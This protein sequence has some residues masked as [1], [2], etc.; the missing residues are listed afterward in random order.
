MRRLSIFSLFAVI[1][2]T[3]IAQNVGPLSSDKMFDGSI[4]ASDNEML[5]ESFPAASVKPTRTS[6]REIASGYH[7]QKLGYTR[8]DN[9]SSDF[10][11]VIPSQ[12]YDS[13]A[14]E[15]KTFAEDLHA[16]RNCGVYVEAIGT[17]TAAQVK[18]LILSY[19]STL[20]GT[21][22]IGNVAECMFEIENDYND[23]IK[24]G[25]RIW[26][27]DLYFM[28][29][30]GIWSDTDNNGVY[31]SHTG[32][33]DPDII[34]GR[35]SAQG[36]LSMGSEV[37]LIRRQLQK[38]H[39]FWWNTSFNSGDIILNYIYR[40]W[41]YHFPPQDIA[42]A[43]PFEIVDDVRNNVNPAFSKQDYLYKISLNG[44]YG[45]THIAAHS[46]A[47]RSRFG[48]RESLQNPDSVLTVNE[49]K[50]TYSSN[51]A[52]NLF[53]CSACNWLAASNDGYLGGVYLF[54]GRKTLAVVGSTKTGGMLEQGLFYSQFPYEKSIGE[55]LLYWWENHYYSSGMTLPWELVSWSYGM[56]LLGDPT[57]IPYYDISEHFQ[58]TL[59]LTSFPSDNQSNMI[60][61]KARQAIHV[62]S[63]Y[64]IPVG[65]HVIFDAPEVVL[66]NGFI[67]PI[68][69]SFEIR[70]GC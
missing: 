1:C 53:C 51:L 28:D 56:T 39:D 17:S 33:I 66:D 23:S 36:L 43:L 44:V 27:C 61:Y 70:I 24:Y 29:L 34:F 32:N 26:P 41:R 46:D 11:V 10:L 48:S 4:F 14:S 13:L 49:L 63:N 5:L 38:S 19:G 7:T 69:A 50:Q 42:P 58:Q 59:N 62:S 16:V 52:Y 15:I 12:L 45:F 8:P 2:L 65:V 21:I 6:N 18:D 67:C 64:I 30:D 9:N 31:D 68:G 60:M 47:T 3:I 54:D 37:S 55:A 35:I 20:G 57:I 25:Y 40:D 22:F